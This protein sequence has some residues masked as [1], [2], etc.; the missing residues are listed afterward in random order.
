M[1]LAREIRYVERI[2]CGPKRKC[3]TV[4]EPDFFES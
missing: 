4:I 3:D 2:G 1:K